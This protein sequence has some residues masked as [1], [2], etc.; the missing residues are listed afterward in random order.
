M[1]DE[2][3]LGFKREKLC[4]WLHEIERETLC[5]YSVKCVHTVPHSSASLLVET[6]ASDA[7]TLSLTAFNVLCLHCIVLTL[8]AKTKGASN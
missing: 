8:A 4:V 2:N 3:T 1:S 5:V 6:F 7:D